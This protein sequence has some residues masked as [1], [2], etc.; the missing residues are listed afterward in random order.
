MHRC[1]HACM[2]LRKSFVNLSGIKHLTPQMTPLCTY[3]FCFFARLSAGGNNRRSLLAQGLVPSG[4][5]SR[6][7][8][9]LAR[10]R[11]CLGPRRHP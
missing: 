10:G 11:S 9:A 4:A 5:R 8:R 7:R 2:R 1:A 3:H 6:R